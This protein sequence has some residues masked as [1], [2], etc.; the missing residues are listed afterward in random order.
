MTD[1]I[2]RSC[3]FLDERDFPYLYTGAPTHA[4]TRVAV[5]IGGSE[6]ACVMNKAAL[7]SVAAQ[8]LKLAATMQADPALDPIDT[9]YVYE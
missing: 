8:L 4:S 1:P 3:Y 5:G 2:T 6:H 9:P 7:E